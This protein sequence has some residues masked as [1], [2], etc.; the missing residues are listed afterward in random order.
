M[1]IVKEVKYT[2]NSIAPEKTMHSHH[3]HSGTYVSHAVDDLDSVVQKAHDMG[4]A[5]FCLTEH[6]PRVN[7]LYLY[8]EETEKGLSCENLQITFDDY[9]K[10]ARTIQNSYKD[11]LKILVGFEVEGVDAEHIKYALQ[12]KSQYDMMVGSVH[13]VFG[14][15]IDF[16]YKTWELARDTTG[17]KT[18]RELYKE[19]FELQRQVIKTLEPQVIGHF[20]LIRLFD[21][22]V[23]KVDLQTDWPE[24]WQLA[25]DNIKLVVEYG[26]LFELNSAAIRKGWN[27]P[28]PRS[29]IAK[30]II[31]NGGR[32]CLSDD[33]HGLKQIGLNYAKVLK[34]VQDHGVEHLYYLD[35]ENGQTVVKQE[36]VKQLAA[37]KFW[38]QCPQL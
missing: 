34:Y 22:E 27:C 11:K 7:D 19:Y 23:D 15:P 4:F 9:T 31:D 6:M 33:S 17:S 18:S 12:L 32:F 3:S 29:D 16:D 8:P 30:A 21:A 24:V 13:H 2:K 37:N 35:I 28:Y 26:G 38:Q 25:V 14:I 10:H 36:L 20:D 5:Q 1:A